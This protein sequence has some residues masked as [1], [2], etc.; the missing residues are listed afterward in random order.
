[1]TTLELA[2]LHLS[3]AEEF[4]E[5]AE[6]NLDQ[7]LYNATTSD[8]IISA[9][10]AKDAICLGL[11]GHTSKS[12][13]HAEAVQE[14]KRAGRAGS[15]LSATLNRLLKLKTRSQY[16]PM[17]VAFR[18]TRPWSGRSASFQVLTTSL[19][20]ANRALSQFS[21]YPHFLARSAPAILD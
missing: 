15:E 18:P 1:M 14:L 13:N 7:K 5:A 17:S 8:A 21:E 2:R 10:N 6:T 16:A 3:K 19:P 4:L 9:I 12:D 11:T 20:A